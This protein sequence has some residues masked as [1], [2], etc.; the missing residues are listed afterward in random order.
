MTILEMVVILLI[1]QWVLRV[2]R[3]PARD[4]NVSR[5]SFR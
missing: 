5:R 1:F 2:P 4:R 3:E